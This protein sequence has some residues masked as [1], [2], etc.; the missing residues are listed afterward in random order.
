[1]KRDFWDNVISGLDT[2]VT[3]SALEKA[4]RNSGSDE[5]IT[6]IQLDS[7]E[8][9][10][11]LDSRRFFKQL[12]ACLALCLVA[13]IVIMTTVAPVTV[14][15]GGIQDTTPADDTGMDIDIVINGGECVRFAPGEDAAVRVEL[16]FPGLGDG[17]V[18]C[19]L[20]VL[21]GE[22]V[23]P[24][25][26]EDESDVNEL[27][28]TSENGAYST[29]FS[30]YSGY[31]AIWQLDDSNQ[32]YR[33]LSI[34]L[35]YDYPS[36]GKSGRLEKSFTVWKYNG[37]F[38]VQSD[39]NVKPVYN[40]GH[41][42]T[43]EEGSG[44]VSFNMAADRYLSLR[45]STEVSVAVN[46]NGVSAR[47]SIDKLTGEAGFSNKAATITDIVY[48]DK[49][50]SGAI[51]IDSAQLMTARLTVEL[52]K[53]A[54]TEDYYEV[55]LTYYCSSTDEG[56]EDYTPFSFTDIIKVEIR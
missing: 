51:I 16:A 44:V 11:L 19:K 37:E 5:Q 4:S 46:I 31:E 55:E 30:I 2:E 36:A 45:H 24:I 7:R 14:T 25:D 47:A 28:F 52:P 40:G 54:V 17:R 9:E 3:A 8:Y 56:A 33:S 10:R 23:I 39:G 12:V 21:D 29:E 26:T 41:G 32:I 53:E 22:R 35:E 43:A 34:V 50:D 6:F 15:P 48:E 42:V 49:T 20:Y 18:S 13:V 27:S 38:T 1:M